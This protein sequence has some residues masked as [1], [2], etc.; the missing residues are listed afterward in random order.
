[1]VYC[2]I[3]LQEETHF[4]LTLKSNNIIISNVLY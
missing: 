1:M 2:V 4:N 3:S